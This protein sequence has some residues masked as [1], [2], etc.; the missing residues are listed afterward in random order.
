MRFERPAY[1]PA[2]WPGSND[3]R[4]AD[5]EPHPQRRRR[6]LR[7]SQLRHTLQGRDGLHQ[8]Y[9]LADGGIQGPHFVH[10][11]RQ[12][13]RV[14]LYGL[15]VRLRRAVH[16][17]SALGGRCAHV[18]LQRRHLGQQLLGNSNGDHLGGRGHERSDR[19]SNVGMHGQWQPLQLRQ[20][21]HGRCQFHSD[22]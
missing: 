9:R 12:H 19:G 7:F 11:V 20:P 14:R 21:Q 8:L 15:P 6:S 22:G 10:G 13:Y 3:A 2:E 5:A 18:H 17:H 4:N 1:S 16:R